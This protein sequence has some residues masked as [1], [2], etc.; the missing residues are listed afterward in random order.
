VAKSEA[1][2]WRDLIRAEIRDRAF[3]KSTRPAS[4]NVNAG[5]TFADVARDYLEKHVRVEGRRE[6]G[7]KLMESYVAALQRSTIP[8]ANG[9]IVRLEDKAMSAITTPD[10]EAI[11]NTWKRRDGTSRAGRVGADRAVKR[12]RHMFNW[13]IERGYV[14]HTPFKRHGVSLVHFKR[15]QSRIRRLE[16]DEERRLLDHAPTYLRALIV[17]ALETGMRRGELLALRWRDVKWELEALLLP[18]EITKTGEPRDVPI[19]QRLK[20]VLELR[21]HAPDGSEHSPEKFV[22]GN[23]VGERIRDFREAWVR[24][25][26]AAKIDGLHFHD[27][28]REFA[29]RLR[30]TPGISDHHVRDWLGH[31]DL[32]T[33]SRYLATTRV[34]LQHARRVFEQHRAFF[35]P[36]LHLSPSETPQNAQI[37]T[38]KTDAKLLN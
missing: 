32:A 24:T 4:E 6:G 23:E 29:S 37:S 8:G 17:A 12:L 10:V 7:R 31:A 33:T 22:F 26:E 25:C 2:K 27:L 19:T 3:S 5:W 28:R 13:A 14:D 9:S 20:A 36:F 34:G 38:D 11:R 15:D 16:G 18:G 35:A 30:E 1:E 21:K